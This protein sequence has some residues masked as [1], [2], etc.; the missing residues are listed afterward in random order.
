MEG[1]ASGEVPCP[2]CRTP[3]HSR[4]LYDA[5][6]EEEAEEAR[7]AASIQGDYGSK[8]YC[9]TLPSIDA[10]CCTLTW[11]SAVCNMCDCKC[12]LVSEPCRAYKLL[13]IWDCISCQ[14]SLLLRLLC[15]IVL[16]NRLILFTWAQSACLNTYVKQHCCI[17]SCLDLFLVQN[18]D[19]MVFK[20]LNFA[21]MPQ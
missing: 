8:V 3:L 15:L 20:C 11:W 4:D 12:S 21:Q 18:G 10:S 13:T 7:Q 19:F 5:V 2:L 14:C 6:T 1:G 17:N 9:C 16:C